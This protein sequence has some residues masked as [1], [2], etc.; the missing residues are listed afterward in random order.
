MVKPDKVE[1]WLAN[2]ALKRLH[3]YL[4]RGRPLGATSLET[5]KA[6]WVYLTEAWSE[7]TTARGKDEHH[8]REDIESEL[9]L[10]KIGPPF[11]QIKACERLRQANK[12]LLEELERDPGRLAS[13]ESKLNAAL[14]Q[15]AAEAKAKPN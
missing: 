2:Q 3:D 1:A 14:V 9:Q 15:F 11:D 6:R 10:R 7:P 12:N 5:L 4:N 8:E 13:Y